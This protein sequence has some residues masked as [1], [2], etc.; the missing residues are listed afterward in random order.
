MLNVDNLILLIPLDERKRLEF[1]SRTIQDSGE[2]CYIVGGAVRDLIM[3]KVPFEYD[4]TTSARPEKVQTLFKRVIETGIQHG[5]VTVVLDRNPYEVTT[6]R[7]EQGY[8]DG[9]RPDQVQ[10]GVS[11][12]EDIERRDF[13]MNS[14]ALDIIG[15]KIIDLQNGIQ[16]ISE[17]IIKTIGDPIMRFSE[18]GLRPIR[19]IRFASTLGFTIHPDTEAAFLPTKQITKMIAVERFQVEL[20]KILD[21]KNP[22]IGIDLLFTYEYFSL[23][24]NCTVLNPPKLEFFSLFEIL[25]KSPSLWK[26]SIPWFLLHHIWFYEELEGRS[27]ST[28]IR[29]LKLSHQIEKDTIYLINAWRNL[30]TWKTDPPSSIEIR[31]KL[32]S[33][34]REFVKKNPVWKEIELF[35]ILVEF[36]KFLVSPNLLADI[37]TTY[38]ASSVLVLGDLCIDGT[39]IREQFPQIQG[40]ALGDCLKTILNRVLE[41]KVANTSDSIQEYIQNNLI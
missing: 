39:W 12:E 16:D 10:F 41:E 1:L 38:K 14:I 5:T 24:T 8:S 31:K 15:K 35:S 26:E 11:L 21:S 34:M 19:G 20:G 40:K 17:R 13:T 25:K 36:C 33:G 28:L 29:D 27:Q 30:E 4:L 37:V 2:E 22:R 9:R 32:L 18:D 7:S 23:F 6:Y 3:G